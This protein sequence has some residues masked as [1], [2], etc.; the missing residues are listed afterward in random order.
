MS[1]L[2]LTAVAVVTVALNAG[3]GENQ[4]KHPL[5]E[6][7]IKSVS[8]YLLTAASCDTL[9]QSDVFQGVSDQ[10]FNTL[11]GVR[12]AAPDIVTLMSAI[13]IDGYKPATL[14]IKSRAGAENS[15]T[16]AYCE[17]EIV[18]EARQFKTVFAQ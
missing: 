16:Q 10:V 3:V 5:T 12:L 13:V 9:N 8:S 14:A 18:K 15:T 6:A 2:I 17:K 4:Q 11:L 7:Q 1:S